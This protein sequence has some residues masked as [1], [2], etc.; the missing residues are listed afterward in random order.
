MSATSTRFRPGQSGNPAGRPP[1]D[2]DARNLREARRIAART[3]RESF[4]GGRLERQ[5]LAIADQIEAGKRDGSV[6]VR[7]VLAGIVCGRGLGRITKGDE[8]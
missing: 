6:E 5:A 3:Y 2:P 1:S 7:S 4:T 8:K